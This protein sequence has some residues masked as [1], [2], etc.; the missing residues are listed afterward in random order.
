MTR[1]LVGV[2]RKHA[3]Y[4]TL[5]VRIDNQYAGSSPAWEPRS[6]PREKFQKPDADL[7]RKQR[8]EDAIARGEE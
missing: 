4:P 2:G 5:N 8:I 3:A 6:A 7:I 1:R